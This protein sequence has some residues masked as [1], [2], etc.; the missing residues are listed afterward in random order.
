MDTAVDDDDATGR[1]SFRFLRRSTSYEPSDS[2]SGGLS[3]SLKRKAGSLRR[4]I[5]TKARQ[6]PLTNT[7]HQRTKSDVLPHRVSASEPEL[8]T[9]PQS[10]STLHMAD[11]AIPDLLRQGTP[12]TKVS[13]KKQKRVTFRLDPEEGRILYDTT[14]LR[15]SVLHP[16]LS[17][18]DY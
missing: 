14:K 12:M 9:I 16:F 15:Y 7:R 1:K 10:P 8:P 5:S 4:S 3:A 13:A 17:E 18:H 6:I 2:T 11:I